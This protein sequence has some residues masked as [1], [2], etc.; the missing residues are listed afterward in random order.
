MKR[1]ANRTITSYFAKRANLEVTN[2]SDGAPLTAGAVATTT[3]NEEDSAHVRTTDNDTV[4][5]SLIPSTS[6]AVTPLT[7]S[8][9]VVQPPQVGVRPV[10][11]D[12]AVSDLGTLVDGPSQPNLGSYP[13]GQ[14]N[15]CFRATWYTS[16]PWLEYSIAKD[17]HFVLRRNFST[18]TSK[19]DTAFTK[20][21]FSTWSKAM[22]KIRGFKAHDACSDHLLSMTRWESYNI[23]KN[24]PGASIGNMLDPGRPSLVENNREYTKTLLEYHRYFCSEEMAYRG[25]DETD[26]SLNAGKWNEFINEG[27]SNIQSIR[28]HIKAIFARVNK[29]HGF[30]G[31]T[32]DRGTDRQ[33]GMYS[34]L[35][36][37]CKD[38]AGHEELSTCFRF[39]N[40]EGQIEERFYDLAR[41][42]ET[43]AQTIVNEG[44]LATIEK[45]SS[46]TTLLALGADGASVMSGCY[47]GVAAKLRRY[48]PWLLYIH[49]AAHR[50]NL[51]VAAYFRTVN[52]ACNVINVYKAL[53][54]IFNVASNREI[55]EAVQKEFY[56]KQPIMAASSLTEV[57]WACKFEGV[58]TMVKRLR[59]ILV[60][61]QKIGA[62][63]SKQADSAAGL[64]HKI[65][66]GKFVI[67]L[68]FLHQLLSI[69]H[70]LSKAMQETNVKWLNVANEMVA[71]RKLLVEIETNDIIETAKE[72]CST[73][74]I[75]LDYEDPVHVSR[76]DSTRSA[77]PREF[78]NRLKA[79]SVPTLLEELERRFSGANTDILGALE[80]LDAS[81]S[82]YLDYTTVQCRCQIWRLSPY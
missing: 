23:Q 34:M 10:D 47:E 81:K 60:S 49:C 20:V 30:R 16:Y 26:K 27:D 50:L 38:N 32:S 13:R 29:S 35:I 45:L 78:C 57:R 40:D 68:C 33:S 51:I 37:E 8:V 46:S 19:S 56:P 18:S 3:V 7:P 61:L 1:T 76:Q 42:K 65:L 43:D 15:R 54:T 2:E 69:M 12:S 6:A 73:V 66:S 28:L 21:G 82:T 36:D 9:C 39:V 63:N 48:Y 80:A 14:K 11:L 22:E 5:S 77:C 25:H 71:V 64:Y 74:N 24:N 53:H 58:N 70:G 17:K 31:S 79:T 55:F 44:V 41:L 59:A 62:S 4:S 67:S 75:T 72:L 52:E